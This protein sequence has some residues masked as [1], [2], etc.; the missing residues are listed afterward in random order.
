MESYDTEGLIVI[1]VAQ[2]E[3]EKKELN[4]KLRIIA[5][6]V[7]H[8]E[9][10]YRKEERPLVARD[11]ELQQK[12]DRETFEAVQRARKEAARVAHQEDMATKARLSRMTTDYKARRETIVAK[13][14]ADFAKRKEAAHKKIEEEK[15]KRRNGVM[16]AREEERQRIE[17]EQ[18]RKRELEEE[19]RRK[20]EGKLIQYLEYLKLKLP[21]VHLQNCVQKNNDV[22]K[23]RQLP[24]LKPSEKKGKKRRKSSPS[25][26]NAK[27]TVPP[28][29]RKLAYSNNEKKK[30]RRADRLAERQKKQQ[31]LL[32][33]NLLLPHPLSVQMAENQVGG[34]IL[35]QIQLLPHPLVRP[36][37]LSLH[38]APRVPAL[39]PQYP[40]TGRE[41][42]QEVAGEL[43]RRPKPRKW[44]LQYL[45]ESQQHLLAQPRLHIQLRKNLK[46]TMMVSRR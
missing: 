35:L 26:R 8:V 40:D 1:Q 22:L 21:S 37:R 5:K 42:R 29:W 27:R 13:K 39:L 19:A 32:H 45:P 3:K 14:A 2:L 31:L 44:Q 20:E 46:R 10:A 36:M 43:G 34:E 17:A 12:N 4:E 7:D 16:K 30:Q 24:P 41:L 25:A 9:R 18:R 38:S 28:L 11:Y 23:R 6:R 33:G 15:T